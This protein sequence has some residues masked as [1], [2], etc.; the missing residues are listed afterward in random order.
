MTP[1]QN[2]EQFETLWHPS[3]STKPLALPVIVYFT[4]RWCKA[5]KRL[6]W[7]ALREAFPPSK[8]TFMI[9]DIDENDYTGGYVGCRSIPGFFVIHAGAGK[10][11]SGPFTNS[12]TATVQEWLQTVLEQS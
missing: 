3:Q 12:S 4:A 8:V 7:A 9:C 11:I 2:Q 10:K 1:L 5:C 6:D